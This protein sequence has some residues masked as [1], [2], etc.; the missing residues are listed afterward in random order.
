MV[1]KKIG[2][3]LNALAILAFIGV[4]SL[5][6]WYTLSEYKKYLFELSDYTFTEQIGDIVNLVELE[7][8]NAQKEV[9]ISINLAHQLLKAQGE[10]GESQDEF[11]EYSALNQETKSTVKVSVNKWLLNGVQLQNSN[12]LVDKIKTQSVETATIFQKIPEG[13]LRISTN[14]VNAQGKRAVG[15]FIP[16]NSP[17]VKTVLNGKTYFGKAKVLDN[18]FNTAYEPIYVEGEIKGILYVG[19]KDRTTENIKQIFSKKK[20]YKNG[21]P[22]AVDRNGVLLIHPN[23]E[24]KNIAKETFFKEMLK[25]TDKISKIKYEWEGKTKYQYFKFY[26]PINGFVSI[27]FYEDDFLEVFNKIKTITILLIIAG[28]GLFFAINGYV[29]N[30]V[31]KALKKAVDLAKSIA[32]GNLS[33]K[34]DTEN[35]C[36]ELNELSLAL[37]E[38]N[39]KLK[40]IISGLKSGITSLREA[41]E[42]FQVNSESLSESTSEQASN[43]EEISSS[44]E[45]MVAN[46]INNSN[47]AENSLNIAGG[48]T[49]RIEK[50][51]SAS[52]KSLESVSKIN[53]KIEIINDI[54]FQTNILALNAAV[55]ASNA[56]QYGKGFAVVA[57]EVR[58]LAEQTKAAA[59]EI[60]NISDNSKED[61]QLAY[62]AM[63]EMLPEIRK[64]SELI[65]QIYYASKEQTSGADQINSAI[66]QQNQHSQKNASSAVEIAAKAE[67][68]SNL[69]E[70][71]QN[72][73][74]HFS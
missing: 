54:A 45:E 44:I 60:T 7:R 13:F 6:S 33:L 37:K 66:Q 64:S 24:G 19:I 1:Y 21:Y 22:Y 68:L 18:Y 56:G 36:T 35:K 16:N 65:E 50:T 57:S 10:I 28:I 71:L 51:K 32:N 74:A 38:M 3:R 52:I 4:I 47:N 14:V 59:E 55:E 11:I 30:S 62:D 12:Q 23:S 17:V 63:I 31:T 26:E 20:Y 70:D 42:L 58:K 5:I 34:I 15:T 48:M 9:N 40:G 49:G 73:I 53:E 8:K 69:A 25:K 43:I 2:F 61:T 39:E 27:T 46:I 41:S 72:L 67:Q 29:I